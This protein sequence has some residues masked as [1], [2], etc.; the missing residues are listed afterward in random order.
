[1]IYL[2]KFNEYG[3][4]KHETAPHVTNINIDELYILLNTNFS[5][6]MT[7]ETR[8]YRGVSDKFHDQIN[9]VDPSK[10]TRVSPWATGNLH[11]L[12]LSNHP[13]WAKYPKRNKSVIFDYNRHIHGGEPYVVIPENNA[14][15]GQCPKADMWEAFPMELNGFFNQALKELLLDNLEE[16][17]L[18]VAQQD[19]EYLMR[20]IDELDKKDE[21][22]FR[23]F[24]ADRFI[25]PH[26]TV[27]KAIEK[28]IDPDNN[29]FKTHKYTKNFNL[30]TEDNFE[31]WTDAKCILVRESVINK[32]KPYKL[33][34]NNDYKLYKKNPF[35]RYIVTKSRV[36][37]LIQ[38]VMGVQE[39]IG[40]F[41][42]TYSSV[43]VGFI[44]QQHMNKPFDC[45]INK[46]SR[47]SAMYIE[48]LLRDTIFQS[49]SIN[50]CVNFI[51]KQL[52]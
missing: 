2:Y 13:L 34:E 37:F 47:P 27:K 23:D 35:K 41:S 48:P 7:A 45:N 6:F 9:V 14:L 20:C 10:I 28:F 17:D 5:N 24:Y 18:E 40:D 21:L 4:G 31:G 8:M 51:K 32:I 11:N 38:E 1:M 44:C 3:W 12:T 46:V 49:D 43:K 42:K 26:K 15:L 25:K 39:Y 30:N 50:R 22:Q 36:N 19:Y 33:Y 16:F 29:N 52:K